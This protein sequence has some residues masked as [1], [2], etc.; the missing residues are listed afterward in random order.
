MRAR[1]RSGRRE[2]SNSNIDWRRLCGITY[3]LCSWDSWCHRL[4]V[5]CLHG[6]GVGEWPRVSPGPRGPRRFLRHRHRRHPCAAARNR[7][8]SR[9]NWTDRAHWTN[10][11]PVWR[12]VRYSASMAE[13][14]R[15]SSRR[16]TA[17]RSTSESEARVWH[18]SQPTHPPVSS[19]GHPDIPRPA[20]CIC[21]GTA[22]GTRAQTRCGRRPTATGFAA[23]CAWC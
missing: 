8:T 14:A 13:R 2:R 22:H 20:A 9:A 1:W 3:P 12:H 23:V 19:S 11:T 10:R 15:S 6:L 21:H 5:Y 7:R 4:S 17:M 16:L 18:L